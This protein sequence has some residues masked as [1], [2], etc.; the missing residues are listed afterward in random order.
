MTEVPNDPHWQIVDNLREKLSDF[1]D[2][3]TRHCPA[4]HRWRRRMPGLGAEM[5]SG[6]NPDFAV[7]IK[8]TPKDDR[9]RQPSDLVAEVVSRRG[10]ARDY[11]AKREE[12]LVF[13]VLEYWIVNP[14]RRQVTVLV[15]R[16]IRPPRR[17]PSAFSSE[18][19]PSPACFCPG[20]R[21]PSPNSGPT[22]N[23]KVTTRTPKSSP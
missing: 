21:P 2:G 17:G 18:T 7:V 1:E 6:R 4:F 23:S 12:Y 15:H 9:G 22:R 14:L 10:E 19:R 16:T 5:I 8:G 3:T 11:Q 13:G 20:S